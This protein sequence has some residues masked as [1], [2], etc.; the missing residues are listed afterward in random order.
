MTCLQSKHIWPP[1]EG[2]HDVLAGMAPQRRVKKAREPTPQ[3]VSQ[4][5]PGMHQRLQVLWSGA[6]MHTDP[7]NSHSSRLC[8]TMVP[9]GRMG[10]LRLGAV[11]LSWD[12]VTGG[13]QGQK[14]MT[15]SLSLDPMLQ[16]KS[17]KVGYLRSRII[18]PRHRLATWGCLGLGRPMSSGRSQARGLPNLCHRSPRCG[19]AQGNLTRNH[20]GMGSIL[21]IAQ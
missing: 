3:L 16:T 1:K 15:E 2:L 10:K 11:T 19:S 4:S 21:G 7:R 5:L 6:E 8:V 12:H 17:L 20:E 13:Q 9:V 18:P 14:E